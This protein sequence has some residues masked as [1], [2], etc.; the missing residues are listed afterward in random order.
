MK[1]VLRKKTMSSS[2]SKDQG[3]SKKDNSSFNRYSQNNQD[4]KKTFVTKNQD[5]KQSQAKKK[6]KPSP[7]VIEKN[8]KDDEKIRE[9]LVKKVEA[10]EKA[11]KKTFTLKSLVGEEEWEEYPLFLMLKR[12]KEKGGDGNHFKSAMR[13][14]AILF[15]LAKEKG[16]SR[17][18][19]IESEGKG[20][21]KLA[22]L[23]GK[24]QENKESSPEDNKPENTQ[25]S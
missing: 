1:Y 16:Y 20:Y 24:V 6:S 8:K 15:A 3:Q 23:Y 4:K 14:G 19:K 5:E 2:P 11:G 18:K 12:C 7:A 9:F 13:V 22:T 10:N 21:K 25:E 17:L